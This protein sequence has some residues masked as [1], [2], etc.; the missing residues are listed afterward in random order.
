TKDD[1]YLA[2][3]EYII[4]THLQQRPAILLNQLRARNLYPSVAAPVYSQTGNSLT[5]ENPNGA[6]SIFYTTDGSDPRDPSASTYSNAVT[7]T[8]SATYKSRV[9]KNGVWSALQSADI[10]TGTPANA[11]NLVISELYYNEPGSAEENEF[12]ELTNISNNEIDLS[13]L[14]FST[15]LTYTFPL[16]T[17]LSPRGRLT[18]GTND[19]EGSL[20][21]AGENITLTDA[22]G[23]I[24]ESFNFD[25][26]PPW[27][28]ASDG[29][30]FSLVR[31][32]PSL[33]LD[34]NLPSSWRAST[35]VGGN[36]GGSDAT[37]FSGG[38]LITYA[39][40]DRELTPTKTGIQVPKNLAADDL[41]QEVQIST[42][43]KN[44]A[45]LSDPT[46]ESLPEDGF[47]IETYEVGPITQATF[48]RLKVTIR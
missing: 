33:Q 44:W 27:P 23:T 20:D 25:D 45:T 8:A 22:S 24:I 5:I 47:T 2:T 38:D 9:L 36:P 14:T 43:L 17:T 4:E 30:G 48:Y 42:D 31:I 39:L 28:Q 6:G 13:N 37:I 32:S 3:Q 19:Y 26:T 16:N 46:Q 15:G 40:Q 1:Q 12:V 18:I 11:T 35:T 29:E 34:P 7:L 10:I 41:I 21:N